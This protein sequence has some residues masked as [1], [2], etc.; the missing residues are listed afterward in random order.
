MRVTNINESE[1]SIFTFGL[2]T[3]TPILKTQVLVDVRNFRDPA[4]A[5]SL[6]NKL[7]TNPEVQ[8]YVSHDPRLS[9]VF[10]GIV[11]W[12]KDIKNQ[13]PQGGYLSLSI[14]DHHGKQLAPAVG[15]LLATHLD[16]VL[17]DLKYKISHT[18]LVK[19]GLE[20]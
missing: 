11:M 12:I 1:L 18:T 9:S 2:K 16:K 8:K 5:K 7:G 14:C 17:P 10:D 15:E 19:L 3:D 4:G 6:K 13:R 20:P